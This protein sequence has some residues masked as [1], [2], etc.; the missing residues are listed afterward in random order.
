MSKDESLKHMA[1][2]LRQGATLLDLQ[3]PLCNTP[4]FRL[5]NGEMY[6]SSCKKIVVK[7][8]KEVSKTTRKQVIASL[9]QT[10]CRKIEEVNSLILKEEDQEKISVLLKNLVTWLDA[11][12]RIRRLERV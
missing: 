8:E 5:K 10:I 7:E 6:C 1:D 3:C 11:L 12:E 4:L 2:L 9:N